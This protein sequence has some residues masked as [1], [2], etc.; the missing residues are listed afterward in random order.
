MRKVEQ[1]RHGIYYQIGNILTAFPFNAIAFSTIYLLMMPLTA[2][3]LQ[4]FDVANFQ[5]LN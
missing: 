1:F 4:N 3:F 2:R 5:R